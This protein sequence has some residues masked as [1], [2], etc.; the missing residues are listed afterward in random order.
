[1][2][3]IVLFCKSYR[4]DILRLRRLIR[5]FEDAYVFHQSSG[6]FKALEKEAKQLIVR[7]NLLLLE[8]PGDGVRFPHGRDA[9]LAVINQS[10]EISGAD[11]RPPIFRIRNRLTLAKI[12]RPRSWWKR[13]RYLRRVAAIQKQLAPC[14]LS[15]AGAIE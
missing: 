12:N 4:E 8:R 15:S 2:T 6:S 13:W 1:M 5:I 14:H 7:N 11:P 9:K 10:A 3:P